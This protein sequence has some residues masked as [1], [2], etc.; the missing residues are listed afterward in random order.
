MKIIIIAAL[1]ENRVIGKDGKLPWH[2]SD[3]LK[4][5]KS[6]TVGHTVL[7]GRKTYESI[8]KPLP[9]RR[10]VV[11]TSGQISEIETYNSI[12][13]A[14]E[15]LKDEEKIFVIGGGT[16]YAQLLDKA[17]CLYLTIVHNK[18]EGDT[19]FP[20]YEKIIAEKFILKNEI[21][22]VEYSFLDYERK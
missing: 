17:D 19:Y 1:N 15:R 20:E 18:I 3:D 12:E 22:T 11:I 7:M 10:N 4:R 8:G 9:N 5:F 13:I 2:I 6:L 16:I 14:L 21:K